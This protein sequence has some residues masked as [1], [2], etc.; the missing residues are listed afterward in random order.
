MAGT[1]LAL[2]TELRL[3]IYSYCPAFTL[4]QLSHTSTAIKSEL[5]SIPDIVKKSDGYKLVLSGYST[6]SFLTRSNI[7]KICSP[8][9]AVLYWEKL[10]NGN[11]DRHYWENLRNVSVANN[12]K[13][14]FLTTFAPLVCEYCYIGSKNVLDNITKFKT[15]ERPHKNRV[16]WWRKC[17]CVSRILDH[18]GHTYHCNYLSPR[19]TVAYNEG[20]LEGCCYEVDE[21][22]K[23]K[24][25]YYP[26]LFEKMEKDKGKKFVDGCAVVRLRR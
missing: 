25:I 21:E 2:P 19:H 3:F 16:C 9:E 22:G 26:D 12:A 23:E 15:D 24:T 1:T 18:V 6:P 13:E 8:E 17:I 7:G 5:Q 20:M 10:Y 11:K 14:L 4:L